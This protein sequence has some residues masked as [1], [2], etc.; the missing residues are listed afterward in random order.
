MKKILMLSAGFLLC[1][2]AVSGQVGYIQLSTD[3]SSVECDYWD[4]NPGFLQVYAVHKSTPGVTAS[5]W[6]IRT[7]GGF[8]G[9]YNG[10]I[11]EV[12]AYSG[13]TQTGLMAVYIACQAADIHVAT[14]EYYCL[15]TSPSC[16][17]IEVA[18]DPR[19][20]SGRIEIN[21]CEEITHY[22]ETSRI[23][24][25]NFQGACGPCATSPTKSTTWGSIKT[26]Y[27]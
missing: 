11:I 7:G 4:L 17:Y 10:E 18:A 21:D 23:I 2:S 19:V 16:A 8:T 3:P 25:N 5:R 12:S 24:V 1:A 14:V 20:S 13:S 22:V 6:M 9:L 27:R 15:G 26:L